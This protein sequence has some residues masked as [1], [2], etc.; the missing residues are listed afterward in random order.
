[1]ERFEEFYVASKSSGEDRIR[2]VEEYAVLKEKTNFGAYI[3]FHL[4][5]QQNEEVSEFWNEI[6]EEVGEI[7]SKQ[8]ES[9]L[10]DES[11]W[12]PFDV[13]YYCSLARKNEDTSWLVPLF[14]K[15][16]KCAPRGGFTY[17]ERKED[18]SERKSSTHSSIICPK[19]G[20][21][22]VEVALKQD[23]KTPLSID[24]MEFYSLAIGE[25]VHDEDSDYDVNEPGLMLP[26]DYTSGKVLMTVEDAEAWM[27]MDNKIR[28]EEYSNEKK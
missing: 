5:D 17:F 16:S 26:P 8:F 4:T 6:M 1:M 9:W 2:K 25:V 11:N 10:R 23:G 14:E 12:E 13:E 24:S 27:E 21:I 18:D 20:E 22:I 19:D 28:M 15:N 7:K 3:R